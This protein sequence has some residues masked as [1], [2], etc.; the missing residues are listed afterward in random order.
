M[1]ATCAPSCASAWQMRCPSPPLPPVTSATTP[2]K[3]IVSLLHIRYSDLILRSIARAMRLEG[4]LRIAAVQAAI[5]RDACK[6]TLLRMRQK[7]QNSSHRLHRRA[8]RGGC[9]RAE[10]PLE[11]GQKRVQ[12]FADHLF[13]VHKHRRLV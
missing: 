10:M 4:W 2:F 9:G 8:P 11:G 12:R 5:L 1:I 6:S 13:L 7:K 3:F